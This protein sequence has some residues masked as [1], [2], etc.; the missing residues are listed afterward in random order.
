MSTRKLVLALAISVLGA[1]TPNAFA[2]SHVVQVN[3]TAKK[4]VVKAQ[5]AQGSHST[6]VASRRRSSGRGAYFIPPPP[7]YM[8][9]ILP[10][11]YAQHTVVEAEEEELEPIAVAEAAKP[12]NPYVKYFYTRDSSAPKPVQNRSGV[13]TWTA[14][15]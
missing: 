12:K 10:E 2:A 11:L 4:P 9:S 6:R 7:A 3:A 1:N 15:K 14:T 13:S 5:K 8:P